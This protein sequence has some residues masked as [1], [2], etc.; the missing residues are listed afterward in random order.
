VPSTRDA[1]I[2]TLQNIVGNATCQ[3]QLDGMVVEGMHCSGEVLLN[4]VPLDC[5]SDDGFRLMGQSTVQLT[6]SACDTFL[7]QQ[8]QVSARFPCGAFLPVD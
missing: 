7:G 5:D 3:I 8:S 1:L 2:E 4:G 6:G